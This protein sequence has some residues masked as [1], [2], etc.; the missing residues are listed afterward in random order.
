MPPVST[1]PPENLS[2]SQGQRR[3]SKLVIA[4]IVFCALVCAAVMALVRWWPFT[5]SAVT[6]DLRE[7]SDNS[8]VTVRTFRE[9]YFPFPGCILQGVTFHRGRDNSH[10]LITIDR[11]TIRGTYLGMLSQRVSRITADGMRVFI[12][13]FGTAQAFHT[14]PSKITVDE[15]VANGS[16]VEFASSDPDKQPLRF[17]VHEAS[18][19]NVGWSGPL[20]YRVKVHN[21]EPPGEVSAEG[22]FGV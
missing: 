6:Q 9:I 21:P 17:D 7:A 13:A 18:L 5:Q 16:A 15:I 11:L 8:Q 20:T 22:K 14:S 12:P 2:T 1:L 3:R 19:K 10:P 4:A